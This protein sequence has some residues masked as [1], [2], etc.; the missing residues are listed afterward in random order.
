MNNVPLKDFLDF[1]CDNSPL[2]YRG[3]ELF[4][5]AVD[6]LCKAKDDYGL[7]DRMP[8]DYYAAGTHKFPAKI[9]WGFIALKAMPNPHASYCEY[10][11]SLEDECCC[12]ICNGCGEKVGDCCCDEYNDDDSDSSDDNDGNDEEES[13][14]EDGIYAAYIA[15]V[16][17]L[18]VSG[19]HT[20][21]C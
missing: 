8:Q 7:I 6:A 4:N 1:R 21:R 13:E 12:D 18:G 11:G 10:C 14:E 15:A 19:V 2:E 3:L 5:I 9:A 17:A 16:G 20:G